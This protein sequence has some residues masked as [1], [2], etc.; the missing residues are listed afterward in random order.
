[1]QGMKKPWV[2][3]V[4]GL[5]A[6]AIL[7]GLAMTFPV[8]AIVGIVMDSFRPQRVGWNAKNAKCDSAIAGAIDWPAEAG[9][10]CD[11]MHMCA[12]EATLSA[13]QRTSLVAAARRLPNC[14]DP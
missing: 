2:G 11:A 7:A 8:A 4:G 1:M 3:V 12:N 13:E 6:L 5:A 9:P 14:P 10:A